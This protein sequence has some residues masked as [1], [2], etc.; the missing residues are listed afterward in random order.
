MAVPPGMARGGKADVAEAV[1]LDAHSGVRRDQRG[2]R[3]ERY[4]LPVQVAREAVAGAVGNRGGEIHRRQVGELV[5]AIGSGERHA[6][7]DRHAADGRP[8][9][10]RQALIDRRAAVVAHGVRSRVG[11]QQRRQ[12][13]GPA[14]LGPRG[15]SAAGRRRERAVCRQGHAARAAICEIR[16]IAEQTDPGRDGQRGRDALLGGEIVLAACAHNY[17]VADVA[18]PAVHG[19]LHLAIHGDGVSARESEGVGHVPGKDAA[20]VDVERG[21][22]KAGSAEVQH[23]EIVEVDGAGTRQAALLQGNA[24]GAE[25]ERAAIAEDEA[26][27]DGQRAAVGC[28][29]STSGPRRWDNCWNRPS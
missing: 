7:A 11:R 1:E 13:D 25:G 9:S 29:G 19:H 22:K 28:P 26:R 3:A 14:E 8:A 20:A 2:C 16:Q 23:G 12:Q 4:V 21:G 27:A 15:Q 10:Q 17:L 18:Q 6:V 24:A 5:G